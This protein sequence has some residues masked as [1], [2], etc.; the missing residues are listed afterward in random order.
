MT[1]TRYPA[2]NRPAHS[3][4]ITV[5]KHQAWLMRFH[6]RNLRKAGASAYDARTVLY[7]LMFEAAVTARPVFTAG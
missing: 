3:N 4:S 5:D 1:F 7:D 2:R 6:Y